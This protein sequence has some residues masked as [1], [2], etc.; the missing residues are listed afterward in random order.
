VFYSSFVQGNGRCT[1]HFLI[2]KQELF[3]PLVV[4]K[5]FALS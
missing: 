3:E 2:A 5:L 1:T 4:G